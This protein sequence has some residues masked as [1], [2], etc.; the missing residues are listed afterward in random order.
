M[1]C[2]GISKL[3][4]VIKDPKGHNL[5]L[6][7]TRYGPILWCSECGAH[8]QTHIRN[9]AENCLKDRA[10]TK[11]NCKWFDKAM[12]PD[13]KYA[14]WDQKPVRMIKMR[15]QARIEGEIETAKD[16]DIVR[17]VDGKVAVG[18]EGLPLRFWEEWQ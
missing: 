17:L 4:N 7:K 1:L 16:Q 13:Y 18:D 6:G 12:H 10:S 14:I 15:E 9:L 11:K 5:F 3:N 8:A 2:P